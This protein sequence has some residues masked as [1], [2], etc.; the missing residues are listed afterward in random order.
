MAPLPE[1][2]ALGGL[3]VKAGQW[4]ANMAATP[5]VRDLGALGDLGDLDPWS[6]TPLPSLRSGPIT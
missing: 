3:F 4:L 1:P 2:E 5:L 6:Q